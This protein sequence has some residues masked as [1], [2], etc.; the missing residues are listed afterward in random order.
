MNLK[1]DSFSQLSVLL[2]EILNW[3][4]NSLLTYMQPVLRLKDA[5]PILGLVKK[6]K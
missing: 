2:P 6:T 1:V 5:S 3:E 4:E